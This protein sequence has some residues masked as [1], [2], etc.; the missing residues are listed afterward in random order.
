M[1][2]LC[3]EQACRTSR[4]VRS[5]IGKPISALEPNEKRTTSTIGPSMKSRQRARKDRHQT[6][7]PGLIEPVPVRTDRQ[8]ASSSTRRHAKSRPK[9]MAEPAG[10]L[11]RVE[12]SSATNW[13]SMLP[14]LPPSSMRRHVVARREQEA[15]G[16]GREQAG[17]DIAEHDRPEGLARRGAEIARS[18]DGGSETFAVQRRSAGS[19]RAAGNAQ[20]PR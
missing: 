18:L 2:A 9:D 8:A 12:N 14:P 10:Q 15:E 16:E 6:S 19:R 4:S 13:P 5:P 7:S 3:R 1:K 20:A 11:K 17:M